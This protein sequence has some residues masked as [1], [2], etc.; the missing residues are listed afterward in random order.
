[1]EPLSGPLHDRRT[2][3]SVSASGV[4]SLVSPKSLFP[5]VVISVF[6]VEITIMPFLTWLPQ[7]SLPVAAS[8]DAIILLV[9]ISLIFYLSY[10]RPIYLYCRERDDT[11]TKSYSI[12]RT[13]RDKDTLHLISPRR[14]LPLMALS[15]FLSELIIMYF[16][17]FLPEMSAP[18][19]ALIDSS[20][21]LVILSP[22]FYFFHYRPLQHHYLDRKRIMDRLTKSEERFKLALE[23]GNDALWDYNLL[24]EEVY[25]SPRAETML[26][27][28]PG[29][30]EP[31]MAAWH[32][33]L[34]P[35]EKEQVLTTLHEHIAGQ[36]S[37]YIA[38]HRLRTKNG[39][40]IW[41]LARG[42]VVSWDDDNRPLRMV[43][44]HSDIT[45][46]IEA[47]E[48]LRQSEEEIRNLSHKLMNTSE[49]EKKRLAQDLHDEF[50]QLLTA[51]QLG[52]EMLR[53]QQY[54]NEEDHKFHCD[55]LLKLVAHLE[56]ELRSIC[57]QLRPVMLDDVGLIE[58]LRWHINEFSLLDRLIDIDFQVTGQQQLSRELEI[59]LYRICQEGLNNITK[60][61]NADRVKVELEMNS[62]QVSLTIHDNG[63]GLDDA[64]P[65][66]PNKSSWGLGL[67]GMRERAAAV[68]GLLKVESENGQGTTIRA[69]LPITHTE[70]FSS[71]H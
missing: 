53:D 10:Y 2:Q 8:I 7:L 59:V 11:G 4:M 64:P 39:D 30:I 52:V 31:N 15:I 21:L 62:T 5:L 58:T 18:L 61:A 29:E 48:A 71:A 56:V 12:P 60:H 36:T 25:V 50:G 40:W 6:I 38:E 51:F 57:D 46:R 32:E 23:A 47:L 17:T 45:P 14:L 20:G 22:T 66:E 42:Y 68:G 54:G 41:V 1:M 27:F 55:R 26:G 35:D 19:E 44:T 49:I 33:L 13:A 9:V 3:K 28:N 70:V 65:R 67:L 37:H 43:G 24:T 34:H 16:L 69:E 63:Q